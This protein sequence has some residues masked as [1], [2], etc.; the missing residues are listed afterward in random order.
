MYIAANVSYPLS[1]D[2]GSHEIYDLSIAPYSGG[3]VKELNAGIFGNVTSTL[4][5]KNLILRNDKI[6]DAAN[7]TNAGMLLGKASADLTVDGVLAYYHEDTYDETKDSSVEVT[8]R[9]N[10]GGLIGLV[11]GGKL[12]VKNAAAA[13]YVKGGSAAGGLIGSVDGADAGSTIVQSY[14]GGHTRDGA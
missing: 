3:S 1:Y 7:A 12:D 6:R 13:V 10:A 14:A 9:Q 4:S 11:S 8:A 2:G 5:V